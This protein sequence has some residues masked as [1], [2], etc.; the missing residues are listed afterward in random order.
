MSKIHAAFTLPDGRV[1]YVAE[2][3]E[4]DDLP[5]DFTV[6]QNWQGMPAHPGVDGAELRIN[7]GQIYWHDSRALDQVRAAKWEEIKAHRQALY[8]SPISVEGIKI[9]ADDNSRMDIMGAIMAMQLSGGGSRMWRC[10]DN[11]MRELTL[12]QIIGAGMAIASRRQALIEISDSLY[13]QIQSATTV[14]DVNAVVW[15]GNPSN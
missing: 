7:N 9:D 12:A 15:P 4:E 8:N 2:F 3:E 14:A 1:Q 6:V 10:S 13:Q 11:V 5:P